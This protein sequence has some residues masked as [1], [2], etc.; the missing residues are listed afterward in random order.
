M[1]ANRPMNPQE[2]ELERLQKIVTKGDVARRRRDE[3]AF[4]LW[5]NHGHTQNDVAERIDRADRRE[6]GS[7]VSH[8]T[9]KKMLFRIRKSKEAALLEAAES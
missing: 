8:F 2:R 3:V 4:D 7:G 1:P 9:T 5:A 6:G